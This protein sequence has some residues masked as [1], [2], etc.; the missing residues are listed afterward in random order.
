MAALDF[1]RGK[2]ASTLQ[3]PALANPARGA[4]RPLRGSQ[5]AIQIGG[6]F[7]ALLLI[8]LGVLAFRFVLVLA[9]G[10]LH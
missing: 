10:F 8:A 2:P 5:F 7:L 6:T 3:A 9:H 4:F 1:A